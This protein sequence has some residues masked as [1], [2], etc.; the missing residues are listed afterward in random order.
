MDFEI[1]P[2]CGSIDLIEDYPV[3]SKGICLKCGHES[4]RMKLKT[5]Y[6][7]QQILDN[8]PFCGKEGEEDD[9]LFEKDNILIFKCKKC[10]RLDGYRFVDFGDPY[11]DVPGEYSY[12]P[13]S[14]EIARQ[15]GRFIYSAAKYQEFAKALRKK[16]KEMQPIEKCK[17][18]LYFLINCKTCEMKEAG[19]SSETINI[20]R[21]EVRGFLERKGPVTRKQLRSIFAA[22]LSLIQ[23]TDQILYKRFLGKKVA[24]GQLEKIFNVTRKTIRKWRK[25]LKEKSVFQINLRKRALSRDSDGRRKY[26]IIDI[27]SEVEFLKKLDKS[28]KG[29]CDF[30]EKPKLLSWRL[31]FVDG[32]WSDICEE[33]KTFIERYLRESQMC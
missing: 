8:C 4:I 12:A 11:S 10:G 14:V 20:V 6:E 25:T 17:Q 15:E 24:D 1:C 3:A 26:K 2:K 18:Q 19:I 5:I 22:A 27:P 21:W 29:E 33:S 30:C 32:S 16:E 23:R 31:Q 13:F 7:E 28:I 9:T